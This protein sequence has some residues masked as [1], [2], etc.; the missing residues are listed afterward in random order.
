MRVHP[1][2]VQVNLL[3]WPLKHVLH[4]TLHTYL[5]EQS[6]QQSKD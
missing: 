4:K 3:K 2:E 6:G 1:L 5:T